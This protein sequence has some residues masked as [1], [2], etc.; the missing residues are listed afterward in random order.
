MQH[1]I[2]HDKPADS[3]PDAPAAGEQLTRHQA[4]QQ[5][6]RR[7][8][9]WMR[10]SMGTLDMVILTVIWAFRGVPQRGRLAHPRVQPELGHPERVELLDHLPGHRL[11][12]ADG[13][14]RLVG[15]R[16][17]ADLREPDQARDRPSGRLAALT[18]ACMH[19]PYGGGRS[20]LRRGTPGRE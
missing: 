4:I 15:V 19:G 1:D 13:G 18:A 3:D 9:F 16:A 20:C 12:A 7:R 5:T 10:T 6:E 17:P 8:R 14:G 2:F 11:G